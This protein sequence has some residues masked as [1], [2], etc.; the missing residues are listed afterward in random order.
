MFTIKSVWRYSLLCKQGVFLAAYTIYNI[1]QIL[2]C[3][4][5]Q[6][7]GDSPSCNWIYGHS[8]IRGNPNLTS[9]PAVT[10]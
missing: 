2:V 8:A 4:Q 9:R 5:C 6:R 1:E 10:C 3:V 7:L